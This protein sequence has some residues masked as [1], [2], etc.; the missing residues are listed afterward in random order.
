MAPRV[1]IDVPPGVRVCQGRGGEWEFARNTEGGSP[2]KEDLAV[3][4]KALPSPEAQAM[5][6][7]EVAEI[8]R[9]ARDGTLPGDMVAQMACAPDVLEVRVGDWW[10]PGGRMLTRLYFSEPWAMPGMLVALRLRTKRPGPLG[11]VE[12]DQHAREAS[13]LL[14]E[15]HRRDYL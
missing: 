5:R 15:Y 13:A 3:L 1:R 9:M 10:F 12:Q 2:F 8:M 4:R 7:Q 11:L 6:M 14:L